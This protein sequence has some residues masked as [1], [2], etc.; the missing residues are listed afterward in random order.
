MTAPCHSQHFGEHFVKARSILGTVSG[1]WAIRSVFLR[2][3]HCLLDAFWLCSFLIWILQ[4]ATPISSFCVSRKLTTCPVAKRQRHSNASI[5]NIR[6]LKLNRNNAKHP[7]EPSLPKLRPIIPLIASQKALQDSIILF[8]NLVTLSSVFSDRPQITFELSSPLLR[9]VEQESHILALHSIGVL[10]VLNG[11]VVK[12]FCGL[13]SHVARVFQL[14]HLLG[15]GLVQLSDVLC[16]RLFHGRLLGL[17]GVEELGEREGCV[18]LTDVR[19][20]GGEIV[21][22]A[23]WVL[24]ALVE[25]DLR[26]SLIGV[27]RTVSGVIELDEQN[28]VAGWI[29]IICITSMHMMGRENFMVGRF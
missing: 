10:D 24:H 22:W 26:G 14:C 11:V 17:N 9:A 13:E 28:T 29:E 5:P 19:D 2:W 1:C 8:L 3:P 27:G 16:V 4:S 25:G 21:G 23:G 18:L 7:S 15:V 6:S 20:V 12:S